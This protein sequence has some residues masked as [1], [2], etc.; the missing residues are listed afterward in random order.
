MPPLLGSIADD[1]T[2]ATDLAGMLVKQGMRTVQMIGVPR[3]APPEGL[4]AIVVA[5]KTRTTPPQDAIDTSLT[6]LEWLRDAGCRQFFL[7]YCSTFDSTS[8]GNIG[9]VADALMEALHT[10]FTVAC[11][12]FPANRRT[13]YRGYLF[14]GDVLLHESGMQNHPLT[15]MTDSNLVRVLQAQSRG[16]VGLIGHESVAEGAAEIQR[17][18]AKART[19]GAGIAIVDAI[20]DSDLI[21][22][23]AACR[24]MPLVTGGSGLG[25]GLA[26]SFGAQGLLP[27][28]AE[29]GKLPHVDGLAA[30]ISGSCSL[31]TQRQVAAM[32]NAAP[33][34]EV[35]PLRLAAGADVVAE[36][37]DWASTRLPGGPI[38]IYA[39]ADSARVKAIQ[40][41]LGAARA[42]A[43]VENTLAAITC[44]L[45]A[46]GVRRLIIAGGETSGAAV[47][48]LGV[49]GLRIGPEI[50][51][52][53][54]WTTSIDDPPLALALKSGNFGT[55]DF[56]LKAWSRLP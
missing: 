27:E 9:P 1:F 12:A 51:P 6:A 21:E 45:V 11:P 17:A 34:F 30:V 13:V 36:A 20:S 35:D 32:K 38:L 31:A 14:V 4:D 56:F 47:G 49:S 43:L 19:Q 15:P 23:G 28:N 54:P 41:Q 25:M 5:L 3:Q 52:G 22:I 33:S 18:Y 2:G 39:T 16:K 26:A 42:G 7:K 53:V 10:D 24:D 50:D 40:E 48:A 37:I 29:A 8:R 55:D 46:A 44:R